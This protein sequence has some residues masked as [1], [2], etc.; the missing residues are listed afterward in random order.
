MIFLGGEG[1]GGEKINIVQTLNMHSCSIFRRCEKLIFVNKMCCNLFLCL[2][3]FFVCGHY[4]VSCEPN[5]I[6]GLPCTYFGECRA[7][8][9]L[10]CLNAV[11]P[12]LYVSPLSLCSV[13]TGGK[14]DLTACKF[15]KN[16]VTGGIYDW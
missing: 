1:G 15:V 13:L 9:V 8:H 4:S 6:K 5:S 3:F 7:K 14:H 10:A 16:G 11:V 2:I 12:C